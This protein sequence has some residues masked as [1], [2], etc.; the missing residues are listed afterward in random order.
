MKSGQPFVTQNAFKIKQSRE[1]NF[2]TS[3]SL[4]QGTDNQ[5]HK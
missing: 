3:L 5:L 4:K 2:F 1:I